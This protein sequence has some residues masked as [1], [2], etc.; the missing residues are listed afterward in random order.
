MTAAAVAVREMEAG[1]E[2][3]ALIAE[4]VMGA[5]WLPIPPGYEALYHPRGDG[6][7]WAARY[8]ETHEGGTEDACPHFSTDIAAAWL[9]VENMVA[10]CWKLDVQNR[11][12]PT[13]GCHVHFA[14]PN[15]SKVFETA[16]SAPLAICRAALVAI[17]QGAA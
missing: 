13:W 1:R 4:K 7:A 5:K 2:M 8:I 16:D 12:A 11:F 3:D 10:R 17:E 14:A 6:R 9:V 15:Y